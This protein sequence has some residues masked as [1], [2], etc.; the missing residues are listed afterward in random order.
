MVFLVRGTLTEE[1]KTAWKRLAA[2]RERTARKKHRKAVRSWLGD[3]LCGFG[4]TMFGILAL[5]LGMYDGM[6]IKWII[7]GLL[8]TFGGIWMFVSVGWRPVR[9]T[10]AP[11]GRDIPPSDMPE[12]PVKAA[13]FGDG[14][15]VF[16]DISEK[17][18]Q[19][20]SSITVVWEDEGRFYLFF[21]DRPPLVLPKRGFAG[22]TAEDFRD[23]LEAGQKLFINR[24][25]EKNHL[26][27]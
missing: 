7:F 20:Y 19:G 13:F 3:K 24:I 4:I 14:C 9:E 8:M 2:Q 5:L 23:F 11:P 6:R 15:F 10:T 27:Y 22:G 17:I 26:S 18:R 25:K 1:D 16:W 12:G 21:R